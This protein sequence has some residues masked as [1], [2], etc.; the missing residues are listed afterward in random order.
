MQALVIAWKDTR[1]RFS[2]RNAIVMMLIAPIVLAL[3][4]GAAFGTPTSSDDGALEPVP[5][6]VANADSGAQGQAYAAALNTG[7]AAQTIRVLPAADRAAA[8]ALLASG[9]ARAALLIGPG[10]SAAL[11][12]PAGP[13]TVE[14][15]ADPAAPIGAAV[16]QA[17]AEQVAAQLGTEVVARRIAPALGGT[18]GELRVAAPAAA[19]QLRLRDTPLAGA[20]LATSP[21]A[22]FVPSM[23]IFF[24]MFTMFDGPRSL[25]VEQNNST[26]GRLRTTPAAFWQVL[27]G[28]LLGTFLTGV[29]QFGLLVLA[30]ALLLG[31]GWGGS[32]AALALMVVAFV[33]AAAGLGTLVAALAKDLTQATM[34]GSS[35]T[36]LFGL[37]GGNFFSVGGLPGWLQAVSMLSVNRWGLSGLTDLTLRGGGLADVLPEAGVLA[38]VAL[39][40][41]AV[42]GVLLPRRFG[43]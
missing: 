35:L 5:V 16:A 28:K 27:L 15:L 34:I 6:A 43:R 36:L 1:V 38:G 42:G 23:A 22:F 20:S 18:A 13:A 3:I 25:L 14:L 29:L 12:Q 37:L 19:P 24:L 17:V 21:L 41:F 39:F 4:M 30:S 31:V 40:G 32:P 2:D 26:L 11:D 33:A 7:A 8:E 10:F 9:E